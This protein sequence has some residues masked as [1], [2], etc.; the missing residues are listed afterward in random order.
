MQQPG[1]KYHSVYLLLTREQGTT[2]DEAMQAVGWT[3]K[4]VTGAFYTIAKAQRRRSSEKARMGSA[5]VSLWQ[6]VRR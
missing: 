5:I 4:A 2:V 6:R 3:R 1:S